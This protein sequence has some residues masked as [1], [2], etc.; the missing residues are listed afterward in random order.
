[1][2]NGEVEIRVEFE[3]F[4]EVGRRAGARLFALALRG[5][6]FEK[7]VSLH[8]CLERRRPGR[9]DWQALGPTMDGFAFLAAEATERGLEFKVSGDSRA[10]LARWWPERWLRPR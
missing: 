3:T 4:V 2:A 1:M 10:R 6:L 9:H 8:L 5:E 7:D